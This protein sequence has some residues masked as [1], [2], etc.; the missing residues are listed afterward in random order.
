MLA[1]DPLPEYKD[2][3]S[4][5]LKTFFTSLG[6]YLPVLSHSE[7]MEAFSKDLHDSSMHFR[8]LVLSASAW[9]CTLAKGDGASVIQTYL[10]AARQA[11][12][13]SETQTADTIATIVTCL[14]LFMTFEWLE[15][16]INSWEFLQ[17]AI[18]RAQKL[19]IDQWDSVLGDVFWS[20]RLRLYYLL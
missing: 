1:A 5:R 4:L 9:A 7:M 3:V 20:T 17:M 14:H 11:L 18:T 10:Q 19:K 6:G 13:L 12:S 2:A 15:D 8:A 16:H